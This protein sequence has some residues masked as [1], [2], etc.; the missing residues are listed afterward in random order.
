MTRKKS[1]AKSL[2]VLSLIACITRVQAGLFFN[3]IRPKSYEEGKPIN[4]YVGRL[5]SQ[6]T[7]AQ[8]NFYWLNYCTSESGKN[9]YDESNKN[10]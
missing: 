9:G 4:V 2:L 3:D 7:T 1:E 10:E 6:R 5:I 8:H